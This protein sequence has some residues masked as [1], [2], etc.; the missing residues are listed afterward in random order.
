MNTYIRTF[1]IL[2]INIRNF[3]NRQHH[4]NVPSGNKQDKK[5]QSLFTILRHTVIADCNSNSTPL[6]HELMT[7]CDQGHCCVWLGGPAGA[8]PFS[9]V[10]R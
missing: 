10:G 5:M 3:K 4:E 7:W 1:M 2:N 9:V 8:A 6:K